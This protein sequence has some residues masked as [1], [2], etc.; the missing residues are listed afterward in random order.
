M[1]KIPE[2][3]TNPMVK[4]E[5]TKKDIQKLKN[6]QTAIRNLQG[7]LIPYNII[8]HNLIPFSEWLNET[9][10]KEKT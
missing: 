4:T 10:K 1:P 7:V 9:L 5:N 8:K 6:T 2:Q 3:E